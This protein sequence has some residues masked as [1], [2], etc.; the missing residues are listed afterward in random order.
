MLYRNH[1][2]N[3]YQRQLLLPFA[4][5]GLMKAA[6]QTQD[7]APYRNAALSHMC[8]FVYWRSCLLGL[9]FLKYFGTPLH[10]CFSSLLCMQNVICNQCWRTPEDKHWLQHRDPLHIWVPTNVQKL[11]IY[12]VLVLEPNL[13]NSLGQKSAALEV[14]H[15]C[16]R[17]TNQTG[18]VGAEVIQHSVFSQVDLFILL[19]SYQVKQALIS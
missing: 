11:Q 6:L 8:I 14:L 4:A 18:F 2:V 19:L 16:G 3:V 1:L 10:L 15:W 5:H 13:N 9:H 7:S 17:N 12:F